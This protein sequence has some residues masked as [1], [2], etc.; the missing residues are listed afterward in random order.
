MN[1][2]MVTSET[3]PRALGA[4]PRHTRPRSFTE[5]PPISRT[6]LR[7]FTA[8]SE[9]YLGRH[10]AAIYLSGP[11]P[12]FRSLTGPVVVYLNHASWW[13][14][15]VCLLLANRF[16]AD[17]GNYAPIDANA[18]AQFRFFRKLGFFGV[19]KDSRRGVIQ[20]LENSAAILNHVNSVL[21]VTP[22]GEFVDPRVRP[23]SLKGAIGQ[24]P[25]LHPDL[26]FVPLA[27]DYFFTGVR[28]PSIAVR[29]G[30]PVAVSDLPFLDRH[31]WTSNLARALETCQ[32][33]LAE[34][35]TS[36]H[37]FNCAPLLTGRRGTGGVYGF[38]QSL[39]RQK[40]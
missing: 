1:A 24:L 10:F 40:C 6:L 23:I 29:F 13:D 35:V 22:Q 37:I 19:E 2:T 4:Q 28:L 5:V 26:R 14:P 25:S 9:S 7:L 18:L 12:E 8:Y 15:L 39:R 32:D 17:R 21:W 20:F 3:L 36:R 38:W 16:F 27:L 30:N 31:E 34:E 33:T 11:K